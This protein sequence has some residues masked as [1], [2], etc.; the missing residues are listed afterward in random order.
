MQ[1]KCRQQLSED[2]QDAECVSVLKSLKK[3]WD[4]LEVFVEHPSIPMDNSEAERRMRGPALGRKNYYGSGSVWS[5]RFTAALF[6][7]F[8]TLLKH[9]INPRLWLLEYLQACA[10][11]GGQAPE[12]ISRFLPWKMSEEKRKR[13]RAVRVRGDPAA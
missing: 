4:G 11:N 1:H 12:D 10:E 7:V 5:G 9:E 6:S 3:H 8:Q 13:L 2:K